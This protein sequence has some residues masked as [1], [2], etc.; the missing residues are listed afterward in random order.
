MEANTVESTA[1]MQQCSSLITAL[2]AQVRQVHHQFWAFMGALRQR[3]LQA[4][5]PSARETDSDSDVDSSDNDDDAPSGQPSR[6][7]PGSAYKG[8]GGPSARC[9]PST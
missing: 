8:S 7:A 9:N 5:D 1:A 3:H 6:N 2:G 4:L